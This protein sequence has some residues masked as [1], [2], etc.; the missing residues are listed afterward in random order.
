M[1]HIY[2]LLLMFILMFSGALQ[3]TYALTLSTASPLGSYHP[4]GGAIADLLKEKTHL[5]LDVKSSDG[6]IDN[7]ERLIKGE[8][9][10]AIVQADMLHK[11]QHANPNDKF[12][13]RRDASQSLTA[14]LALFPE[15]VQ[16]IV[17]KEDNIQSLFKL[18][19]RVIYTGRPNSG[20]HENALDLLNH[21]DIEYKNSSSETKSSHDALKALRNKELDAVFIT[22]GVIYSDRDTEILSIQRDLSSN[23]ISK[24]PY[25]AYKILSD[26]ND[27]GVFMTRA[28]LVT[29]KPS[30]KNG[31]S[32]EDA[33]TI[34]KTI[35]E[36]PYYL[37]R[38]VKNNLSFFQ[39]DSKLRKVTQTL[40]PGAREYYDE[41]DILGDTGA[42]PVTVI[43]LVLLLVVKFY[44]HCFN[45]SWLIKLTWWK[46][47]RLF[48]GRLSS[49]NPINSIIEFLSKPLITVTVIYLPLL[50]SFSITIIAW[51]EQSFTNTHDVPNPFAGKGVW[52][53]LHWMTTF[54]VTGFN[55]DMYP[56]S[57]VAKVVAI[58][59]PIIVLFSTIF[60]I[61]RSIAE[62][63]HLHEKEQ[64]GLFF[65]KLDN[66]VVICGWN[67][68]VPELIREITSNNSPRTNVS[69]LVIAEIDEEKPLE[70]YNF[71][72]GRVFYLRGVPSDYH[73]L[74]K[75]RLEQSIATIIV[76]DNKTVDRG[77][78]RSVF[79][80]VAAKA[81]LSQYKVKSDYKLIGELYYK[82]N[83]AYFEDAG[84][85]KL[86]AIEEIRSRLMAHSCLNPGISNFLVHLLSFQSSQQLRLISLDDKLIRKAGLKL[87]GSTFK[88]IAT[89]LREK[90]MLLI[91]AYDTELGQP[92]P[93]ELNFRKNDTPYLISPSNSEGAAIDSN[94]K[95]IISVEGAGKTE[96]LRN[97]RFFR[98]NLAHPFINGDENLLIIGDQE[99][100][101]PIKKTLSH[102]CLDIMHI[103]L[104]KEPTESESESES[105]P[106]N[107]VIYTES[108][109]EI[110]IDKYKDRL[111]QV[112]RAMILTPKMEYSGT[113][114]SIY[115][116]DKTLLIA[117]DIKQIFSTSGLNKEIHII[118]EIRNSDN[119]N[120]FHDIGIS[121]PIATNLFIDRVLANMAFF[122]GRV[123]E[124]FI[125]CMG[126][127]DNNKVHLVKLCSK[128]LQQFYSVNAKDNHYDSLS[129]LLMPL[130]VQLMA[131]EI[132]ESGEIILNPKLDSEDS[133]Y[134]FA[135]EDSIY[136]FVSATDHASTQGLAC[137]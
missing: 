106:D 93:L 68:R 70:K 111:K 119:L 48:Y 46:S 65:R 121:Q 61:F 88:D 2:H 38:N 72:S 42:F 66:H 39:N 23:F 19:N 10:L 22:S 63:N 64:R 135:D 124:F 85:Y 28:I 126:Y 77:N 29:R 20:A 91:A 128:D 24:H 75:A 15:Y 118:A 54:A 33:Y 50:L 105:D 47:K 56:N 80:T 109:D 123:S 115:Q 122:G 110:F 4:T 69:V 102:Y 58:L 76:A 26:H 95:L 13:Q 41:H 132:Q 36:A 40:H 1:R 45:I 127:D 87:E 90:S 34:T 74:N 35:F 5:E 137:S 81:L 136:A 133:F 97:L 21:F 96:P 103:V 59:I 52:E 107:D 44:Q 83:Q 101:L 125:K 94:H 60:A 51:S 14:L 116:D 16:V 32:N 8:T 27:I 11:Y 117:K 31:L 114:R 113:D 112:T 131:I 79:T 78:L 12:Y 99:T 92:T 25:Y 120:L 104:A 134:K 30:H 37:D 108:L 6:S 89:L 62:K 3:P 53:I 57:P 130:G 86:A 98:A 129:A 55:Q 17:R 9:D 43:L 73:V 7:I 18:N 67:A 71:P 82:K 100:C 49:H 84:I